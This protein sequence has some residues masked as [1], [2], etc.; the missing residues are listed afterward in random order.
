MTTTV[1]EQVDQAIEENIWIEALDDALRC[2][3]PHIRERALS[4]LLEREGERR[5]KPFEIVS[6]TAARGFRMERG[7]RENVPSGDGGGQ[8]AGSGADQIDHHQFFPRGRGEN[9]VSRT[10]QQDRQ[11]LAP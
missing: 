9:A 8:R 1:N 10:P 11:W 6:I 3:P 7:T 5:R 4:V 2:V